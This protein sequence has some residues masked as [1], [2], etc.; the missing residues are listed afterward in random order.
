[1]SKKSIMDYQDILSEYNG[2]VSNILMLELILENEDEI[3]K[4]NE[5]T[6][7]ESLV[8]IRRHL[9]RTLDDT[10]D[11]FLRYEKIVG[12]VLIRDGKLPDYETE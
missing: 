9:E 6:F 11:A 8:S 5:K 7:V 12:A 1:M 3:G 4:P 10:T 2:I